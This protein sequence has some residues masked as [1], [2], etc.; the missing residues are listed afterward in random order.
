[1]SFETARKAIDIGIN[2]LKGT[3]QSLGVIFFGGEPLLRRE[4]ITQ[5]VE[6][7]TEIEEKTGQLFHYKVTTNGTLLDESFLS[8]EATSDIFIALSHDGVKASQ[9]AH[10]CDAQGVGTFDILESKIDLLLKHKPY[11]P[12]MM[13]VNPDTVPYYADSVKY[14]YGRGFRY[15]ICSLNYNG[16]WEESDIAALR[17]QY[18][19][20]AD[21]YIEQ[22]LAEKKFYY[23]PF[24]VKI[25]SHVFPGSCKADRCEL[26]R[27]Q[28]SVAPNGRLFPCVQFVGDGSVTEYCIGDVDAGIDESAR[29]RLFEN[30][31]EEKATC[32]SCAIRERCNHYCG[33]L[34]LATTG[35]LDTVSPVQCAHERM[36]LPIADSVGEKLFKKR[37]AMFI[38]K[39][40][41]EM[42]PLISLVEDRTTG[43][44][45]ERLTQE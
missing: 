41:N 23:S 26:G 43:N 1:M 38:Q 28:I 14:L 15:L 9:N 32:V 35:S 17:K 6:Y 27:T 3:E 30:N 8:D 4:L 21:W 37:S 16:P 33:C 22:T 20:L 13:V 10:R 45:E 25:A 39:H 7:C 12:V 5:I 24:E 40:Y 11:S 36:I 44:V 2:S 18:L 29:Q 19:N 42:F 34:N 31:A